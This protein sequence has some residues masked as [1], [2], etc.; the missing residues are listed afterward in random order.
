VSCVRLTQVGALALSLFS[1][2]AVAAR[3]PDI[4]S[5]DAAANVALCAD[6]P[7]A[8]RSTRTALLRL[9]LNR[10]TPRCALAPF[11]PWKSRLKTVLE[12]TDPEIGDERDFG[13][14]DSSRRSAHP[15]PPEL[16]VHH[17]PTAPPLRC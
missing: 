6:S 16:A 1:S 12:E 14:V 8:V 10:F 11:A 5:V 3:R 7:I 9:P 13:A 4:G 2:P 15:R 17:L